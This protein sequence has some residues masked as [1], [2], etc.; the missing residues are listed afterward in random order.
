MIKI[1]YNDEQKEKILKKKYDRIFPSLIFKTRVSPF[2]LSVKEPFKKITESIADLIEFYDFSRICVQELWIC[3]NLIDKFEVSNLDKK[4]SEVDSFT[5]LLYFLYLYLY[6]YINRVY[7][8]D[9]KVLKLVK[10]YPR[11]DIYAVRYLRITKEYSLVQNKF[12]LNYVHYSKTIRAFRS[13]LSN[14]IRFSYEKSGEVELYKPKYFINLVERSFRAFSDIIK[15]IVE[16]F[17]KIT[18]S[19]LDNQSLM[20]TKYTTENV[21]VEKKEKIFAKKE[22]TWTI[23]EKEGS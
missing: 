2:D 16:E 6:D 19:L 3:L 7:I 11:L 23:L 18:Q 1:V 8:F 22:H 20:F 12:R 13:L 5:T 10:S 14:E 4:D 9:Q 15:N 21:R 17:N